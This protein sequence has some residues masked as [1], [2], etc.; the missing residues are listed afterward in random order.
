MLK[1]RAIASKWWV[2]GSVLLA[3][4][5]YTKVY[6]RAAEFFAQPGLFT[7][8]ETAL[9]TFLSPL[10]EAVY[11]TAQAVEKIDSGLLWLM[12]LMAIFH[13]V[14]WTLDKWPTSQC[15]QMII[16]HD[17]GGLV[18]WAASKWWVAGACTVVV[19][20]LYCLLIIV[21]IEAGVPES[22]VGWA[23]S[24]HPIFGHLFEVLVLLAS[25]T[26]ILSA[27]RLWFYFQS[28]VLYT[29]VIDWLLNKPDMD[30]GRRAFL[31]RVLP[32]K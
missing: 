4:W 21:A 10:F 26:V 13:V 6:E 30:N 5:L 17:W 22:R 11:L 31:R 14:F 1:L 3:A 23:I 7:A 19:F 27:I 2:V 18:K 12:C 32:Y 9:G 25:L 15:R 29:F 20:C 16:A 24:R 28:T 8:T